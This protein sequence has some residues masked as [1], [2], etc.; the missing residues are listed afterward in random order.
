VAALIIYSLMC[1][2]FG[3]ILVIL[4]AA[5]LYNYLLRRSIIRAA[6]NILDQHEKSST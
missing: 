3:G 2:A 4:L 6:N 5:P 1:A